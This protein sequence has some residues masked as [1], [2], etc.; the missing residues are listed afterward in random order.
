[1]R[2]LRKYWRRL[3]TRGRILA[4]AG[5]AY[6]V[7]LHV[8]V[9]AA[10]FTPEVVDDQRWRWEALQPSPLTLSERLTDYFAAQ[11]AQTG[12]GRV[13]F[14]GDSHCHR[15]DVAALNADALQFCAGGMTMDYAAQELTRLK[16]VSAAGKLVIWAGVND[17]F[18]GSTP[19]EV[20]DAA[21]RLLDRTDA[22]D[23][24]VIISIPPVAAHRGEELAAEIEEAN[25][26]LAGVCREDCILIDTHALLADS[27]GYLDFAYDAGDGL[28]LGP[29][30]YKKLRP[31]IEA[32]LAGEAQ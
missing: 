19:Q 18:H 12:P 16:T 1:M 15:F 10:L 25:E 31:A 27:E 6:I 7:L 20:V 14:V 3:G 24:H 23:R 17:L 30:G 13:V 29:R 8:F 26:G 22:A 5:L 4:V 32:A 2:Q 11:D 9:A 21:R 28:H